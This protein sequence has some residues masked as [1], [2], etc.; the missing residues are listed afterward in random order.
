MTEVRV[1][2]DLVCDFCSDPHP[3]HTFEAEDNLLM[4]KAP[5]FPEMR[6]RGG[7]MACEACK[8]MIDTE[9]WNDLL[10]RS[11]DAM[12]EKHSIPRNEM[13]FVRAAIQR[14]HGL[15]RAHRKTAA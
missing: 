5:G 2:D 10:E 13:V 12:N 6:S 11:V 8:A 3:I 15:F 7:W 4:H 1:S 14:S 9:R